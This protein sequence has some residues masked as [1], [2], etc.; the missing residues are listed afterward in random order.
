ML[1][2]LPGCRAGAENLFPCCSPDWAFGHPCWPTAQTITVPRV[3]AEIPWAVLAVGPGPGIILDLQGQ[4]QRG[5]NHLICFPYGSVYTVI[6]S[7]AACCSSLQIWVAI[8]GLAVTPDHQ[9]S[10][11]GLVWGGGRQTRMLGVA[12]G[13]SLYFIWICPEEK[14]SALEE[15]VLLAV[16]CSVHVPLLSLCP[17]VFT[18]KKKK[19]RQ[20]CKNKQSDPLPL[21]LQ[22]KFWEGLTWVIRV[23][24]V[25]LAE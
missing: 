21:I 5:K 15:D 10:S 12:F 3:S 16:P 13:L 2:Y 18:E 25:I 11:V 1:D 7:I 14:N 8:V 9:D 24:A 22:T 23:Q 19:E 20:Y 6:R 17:V 4:E